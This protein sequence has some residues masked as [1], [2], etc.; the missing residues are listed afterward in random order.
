[1]LLVIIHRAQNLTFYHFKAK[2]YQ[3]AADICLPTLAC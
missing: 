2:K 3:L 1:M